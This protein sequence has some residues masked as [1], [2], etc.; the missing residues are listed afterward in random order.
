MAKAVLH[1][2]NFAI[3]GRVSLAT[4]ARLSFIYLDV[5]WGAKVYI[6]FIFLPL[7]PVFMRVRGTLRRW[8]AVPVFAC[9]LVRGLPV[10][11]V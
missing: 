2:L 6:L 1:R 11:V 3:G 5:I 10:S 7:I 8:R 9:P 4:H